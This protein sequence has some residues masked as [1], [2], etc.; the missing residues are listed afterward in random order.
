MA[1]GVGDRD[2]AALRESEQDEPVELGRI[3]HCLE[4]SHEA[5][6][7]ELLRLAIREPASALVVPDDA[8]TTPELFEPVLPDRALPVV[9]QVREPVR[10]LD[11]G[12]ADPVLRV[13]DRR[14]VRATAEA[15]PL[16]HGPDAIRGKGARFGTGPPEPR[17]RPPPPSSTGRARRSRRAGSLRRSG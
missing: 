2:R 1:N 3:D 6:E 16:L 5:L 7:R 12:R 9:L 4:I 17:P 10:S 8:V 11:D 15:D 13:G 14:P